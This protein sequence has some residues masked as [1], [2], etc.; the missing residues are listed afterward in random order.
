MQ[1]EARKTESEE[2]PPLAELVGRLSTDLK[3]L[4]REE[5]ELAK[6]ELGEKVDEAKMQVAA[7]ALG[8]S[9]I[10]GG[11][12]VLLAA[13]V[14]GLAVVMPAWLAALIVGIVV[15]GTGGLLV[16][17]GKAKLS[18]I[19]VKPERTLEGLRRDVSAIKGAVS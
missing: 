17:T 11:A 10:A 18:R 19:N 13:A 7:L 8:G 14:L 15:A 1:I 12:L 5:T 6:R 4:A 2:S 3:L 9:A 16:M